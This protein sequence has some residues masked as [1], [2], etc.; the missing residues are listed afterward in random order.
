MKL[1]RFHTTGLRIF[2]VLLSGVSF[3]HNVSA[4]W[5]DTL[6]MTIIGDVMMHDAQIKVDYHPFLE[7]IAP[8]LQ[9]A[10]IAVANMEFSLGGKPYSGYP[11]FSAPDCIP[12]Y[13]AA[14]G[15]D[16]FLTANNHILDRGQNGMKR[17]LDIYRSM[18]DSVSFT[19]SAASL[20][21]CETVYPLILRK[22][23][24]RIALVNFTYGTNGISV[25]G[26]P[27]TFYM[28]EAQVKMALGRARALGA[29]FIVALPHWGD[30]YQ[31]RHNAQ[32]ERWAKLLVDGGADVIVGGHPHVVQDTAHIASVPVIYSMGNAVSNMS[33]ENTRLELA[34]TLLFVRY[35]DGSLKML[36]PQLRW[37]WCTLPGRLSP[38]SHS[39][40]FVDEWKD[41]RDAWLLPS[42]YDNMIRTLERVKK[43]TGIE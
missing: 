12:H 9:K 2:I 30:E 6:R 21:E 34:V 38:T 15:V 32:Q 31:L 43:A 24:M 8:A 18:S 13:V 4:Q 39:T 42:D 3:S 11:A 41:K 20:I 36:E 35:D 10:D 40:V 19:G 16:V 27:N 28:D 26:W 22:N 23:G 14:C 37:M 33:A 7:H 17:T 1:R 29:D 25:D 5:A